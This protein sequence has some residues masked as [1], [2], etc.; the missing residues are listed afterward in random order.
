MKQND[1]QLVTPLQQQF[2]EAFEQSLK[3]HPCSYRPHLIQYENE[4]DGTPA[5]IGLPL[6]EKLLLFRTYCSENDK[7]GCIETV[8]VSFR[9]IIAPSGPMLLVYA[10]IVISIDGAELCRDAAGKCVA[11]SAENALYALDTAIQAASGLATSRALSKAGFGIVSGTDAFTAPVPANGMAATSESELPFT[12]SAP[13]NAPQQAAAAAPAPQRAPQQTDVQRAKGFICTA[14]GRY[15]GVPL[16]AILLQDPKT[17]IYYATNYNGDPTL[18]QAAA[19]LLPEAKAA[20][21]T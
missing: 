5:S 12:M 18:K 15:K 20:T 8:D 17:I 9:D 1:I 11:L 6:E 4:F 13:V 7:C 2:A 3:V 16:G 21:G 10:T 19:L 14:S